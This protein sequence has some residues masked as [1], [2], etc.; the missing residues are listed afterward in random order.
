MT[1]RYL[2]RT[3]AE[4]L[5]LGDMYVG[6]AADE[7][8]HGRPAHRILDIRKP[9]SGAYVWFKTASMEEIKTA[10]EMLMV[11]EVMA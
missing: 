7:A 4:D 11:V 2:V 10:P 5:K 8:N 9:L 1:S 6:W 3:K